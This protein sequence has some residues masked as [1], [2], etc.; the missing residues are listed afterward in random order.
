MP[1]LAEHRALDAELLARVALYNRPVTL[2][3]LFRGGPLPIW[4]R[5]AAARLIDGGEIRRTASG[6]LE[7]ALHDKR[8]VTP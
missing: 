4:A 3:E 6:A 5:D 8:R 2:A 1:T 7:L